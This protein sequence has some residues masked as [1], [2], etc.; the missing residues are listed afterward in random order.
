VNP[1]ISGG[2]Y[3]LRLASHQFDFFDFL[4]GRIMKEAVLLK[5]C[6]IIRRQ[7]ATVRLVKWRNRNG[8]LVLR[9]F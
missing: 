7:N 3:F 4:F 9:P 5:L 1:K 8:R 6:G 2:G